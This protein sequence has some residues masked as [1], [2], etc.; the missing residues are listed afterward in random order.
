[1]CLLNVAHIYGNANQEREREKYQHTVNIDIEWRYRF[2]IH[3]TTSFLLTLSLFL[4]ASLAYKV[5]NG[6]TVFFGKWFFICWICEGEQV[7]L[8][9]GKR[10]WLRWNWLIYISCIY[11]FLLLKFNAKA[12]YYGNVLYLWICTGN[13]N[14]ITAFVLTFLI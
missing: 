13:F 1:M 7:M 12:F 11:R 5:S 9:A 8:T 14:P 2:S 10:I 4:S 6:F 3:N